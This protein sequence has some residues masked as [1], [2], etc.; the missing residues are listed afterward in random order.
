MKKN[1]V[2]AFACIILLGGCANGGKNANVSL[3]EDMTAKQLL[4]GIWL[5]MDDKD[6]AFRVEGDTIYYPDSISQPV[7]IQIFSDTIFFNGA[8]LTKYPIER[9]SENFL[10]FRN[11]KGE[12]VKLIKSDNDDDHLAFAPRRSIVLNLRQLIKC[13]TVVMFSNQRYHSYVQVNPTTYRVVKS[14]VNDDGLAI[15]NVY[16]DNIVNLTV[17]TRLPFAFLTLL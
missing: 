4:Q 1:I 14:T 5:N 7:Y 16:Y 17:Y 13:D 11:Q 12:V 10:Q 3:R 2:T 8:Q 15:D 9:Q 6:V